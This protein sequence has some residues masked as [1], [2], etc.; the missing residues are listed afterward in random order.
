MKKL[1]L[2]DVD[3]TIYLMKNTLSI[4]NSI[5][6]RSTASF[7]VSYPKDVINIIQGGQIRIMQDE[8]II[9]AGT[10]DTIDTEK[11]KGTHDPVY[12]QTTIQCVDWHQICDRRIV[13]E[14]YENM[15]AGAIAKSIIDLYL[16]PE[17]ITYTLES[18]QDGPVVQQ[19]V[20]NYVQAT[21]CFEKLAE[22]AGFSWWIDWDKTLYFCDRATVQ[23][24]FAIGET[25]KIINPK[26]SASR[27]N[28]RNRQYIRAGK[29]V[30]DPQ[31]ENFKGDGIQKTFTVGFPI[32]KVPTVKVNGVT[33]TVGIKGI[34]EGKDWY[35]NK[36][37]AILTQDDSATPLTASDTLQITYQGLYDVIVLTDDYH[38]VEERKAIEGGTGYYENVQEEPY[39]TTSEVAFQS[40]NAYLKKYAKMGK[41][42]TFQT[43]RPGLRSGQVLQVN[44]PNLGAIGE[45][46]IQKVTY[47]SAFSGVPGYEYLYTIEAASNDNYE[48][49]TKFF[50]ANL[51][52]P[53]TYVIRENIQEQEMLIR[54]VQQSENTNWSESMIQTVF[55]CPIPSENLY[56]SSTLYP[57]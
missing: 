24:P 46:L 49:W 30:T 54:L 14:A 47:E 11:I 6:E 26:L 5:G 51:G 35:W 42:L 57:C 27:D 2:N 55:A 36:G 17:G 37:D 12:H 50:K 43:Y 13:S 1:Y 45:F 38:A 23:A 19:A 33:K 53:K 52:Q 3:I 21:V 39:A 34:D 4:D 44:L 32:A 22:L 40:A 8:S 48:S 28:Y 7:T 31:T 25:T 56:P 16:A 15:M 41:Q 18:I 9:F 29:D 20:F 10:V